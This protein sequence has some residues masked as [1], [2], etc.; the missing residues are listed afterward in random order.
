MQYIQ[1]LRER[2]TDSSAMI[3]NSPGI[4][5]RIRESMLRFAE[6]SAMVEGHLQHLL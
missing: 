5:C 4:F 6:F 2:I 1:E 3:Q